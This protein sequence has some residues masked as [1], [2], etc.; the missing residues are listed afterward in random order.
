MTNNIV[1]VN[2]SQNIGATPSE[3]Q[4]TGALISQG[5]TTTAV[6]TRTLLTTLSDL[7]LILKGALPIASMVWATS[8]VTVTAAAPHGF[9][10]ADT[11]AITIS[12]ATPIGYNGTYT[13]TVTSATAFTFPLV[14]NPGTITVPGKYTV[15]DVDELN[16]MATTF[17]AQGS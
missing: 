9:T 3:L 17:F 7:A 11:L 8:V 13:A 16:D 15:E 6:N 10:I 2:V 1:T 14:A 5:A 12:G 4:R